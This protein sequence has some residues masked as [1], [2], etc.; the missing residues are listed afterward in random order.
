[1]C[2]HRGA[3]VAEYDREMGAGWALATG[4]V[5][6]A[7]CGAQPDAVQTAD[8][9]I[10]PPATTELTSPPI[11]SDDRGAAVIVTGSFGADGTLCPQ[12]ET[13]CDYGL[14]IDGAVGDVVAGDFVVGQGW[15]DGRRVVLVAPFTR[16]ESPFHMVPADSPP[17]GATYS[18][19]ELLDA[20]SKV[21]DM[22]TQGVFSVEG[23]YSLDD[24]RDRVVV[25]IEALDAV[26]RAALDQLPAVVAVP[27]IELLDRPLSELP[28]WLSTVEGTVDM[29]TAASRFRGGMDALGTF[30][31][32]YDSAADCLY[33][34][35]DDQRSTFVWPFGYSATESNGIVTVFDARGAPV[36]TSGEQIQLGGGDA[37][38]TNLIGVAG[39]NRCDAAK[40]WVVNGG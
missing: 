32:N 40:F 24:A 14:A 16:Q 17:G 39:D 26:G 21:G 35:F 37:G 2:A 38:G 1:V 22:V 11:S 34:E 23:G 20:S 7:A 3:R 19:Q 30:T 29:L 12:E 8:T 18:Q 13:E 25:P 4:V 6:A 15:Y 9:D 36:A 28:A 33:A 5:L 27:F 31:M 10:L